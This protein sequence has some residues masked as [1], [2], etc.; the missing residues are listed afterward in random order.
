MDRRRRALADET[1]NDD[2]VSRPRIFR[3]ETSALAQ[4]YNKA[5]LQ[6]INA[7]IAKYI[8]LRP[9]NLFVWFLV[10]LIPILGL[11]LL[12]SYLPEI[13]HQ[14]GTQAT[15]GFDLSAPGNLMA[16]LSS[17]TFGFAVAV[18]LGT[19][20]VRRHRRD[21]YRGRFTVWRWAILCAVV[22]SIDATV[23]IHHT[24]QSICE[25]ATGTSLWRDGKIW[26]IGTWSILLGGMLLRLMFEM[27]SSKKAVGWAL[28]ASVCYLWSAI[29]ELGVAPIESEYATQ[30]SQVATLLLG[31]HL[32]LFSLVNYAREVVLEAMGLVDSPM[33]RREKANSAKAAKQAKKQTKNTGDVKETTTEPTTKQTAKKE[34][35]KKDTTKKTAKAKRKTATDH[36]Y[37]QQED[38][39]NAS[40][41]QLRAVVPEDVREQSVASK[42]KSSPLGHQLRAVHADDTDA[43]NEDYYDEEVE[44]RKMT[45]AEKRRLRKEQKRRKAA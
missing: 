13:T 23:G 28:G 5:A 15:R 37:D 26:W 16:W 31:H 3:A 40:A 8:P 6:A 10:G 42:K 32:M 1:R 14:L 7:P 27:A 2:A 44:P 33:V 39:T 34:T 22:V 24:W 20:S 25:F 19:Y 4:R 35:S 43:D 18:M 36:S 30:T 41:P 45:K 29:V 38:E 21:D 17:V 12:D 9:Y 11:L